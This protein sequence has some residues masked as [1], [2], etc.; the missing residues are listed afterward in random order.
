M[1]ETEAEAFARAAESMIGARFRL[2]GRDPATGL[3]CVGLVFAS[4]AA[5]GRKPSAPHGYGLRNLSVAHWLRH[6]GMSGLERVVEGPIMR[7]DVLMVQPS[8]V[9]HHLLIA[10]DRVYVVHAHAA[11]RKVVCEP[12]AQNILASARW[13]LVPSA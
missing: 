11:L 10:R 3:D 8:Q 5:I 7:G 2:H 1:G 13:R 9:Q 12:L 6:A 4:L